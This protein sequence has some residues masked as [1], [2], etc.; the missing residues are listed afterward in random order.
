ML[1]GSK[2]CS[3]GAAGRAKR[4]IRLSP[5]GMQVLQRTVMALLASGTSTAS[6]Q[7]PPSIAVAALQSSR[8]APAPVVS[9]QLLGLLPALMP[10]SQATEGRRCL[11][12]W[13]GGM[14]M[15]STSRLGWP[16]G[17]RREEQY[18]A[19]NKKYRWPIASASL[20]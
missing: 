1:K 16:I 7:A 10:G 19:V 8:G 12:W 4:A 5:F 13:L 14:A 6:Q 3:E 18:D 11:A 9:L 15:D 17:V 2:D 20:S